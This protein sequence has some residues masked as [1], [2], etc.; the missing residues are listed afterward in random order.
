MCVAPT[1]MEVVVRSGW[2]IWKEG[3]QVWQ[4]KSD[5]WWIEM[6]LVQEWIKEAKGQWD[7][8]VPVW[9]RGLVGN[10]SP[11]EM[12]DL[13]SGKNIIQDQFWEWCDQ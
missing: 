9:Y 8:K 7:G 6:D 4:D 12:W 3:A 10:I 5:K 1:V 2:E 13:V 11:G